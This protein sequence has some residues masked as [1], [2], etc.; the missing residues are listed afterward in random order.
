MEKPKGT[1]WP[2]QHCSFFPSL[3]LMHWTETMEVLNRNGW[4]GN[5]YLVSAHMGKVVG[6]SLLDILLAVNI[7][8]DA[9]YWIDKIIFYF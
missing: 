6:L 8:T 7:F 9:L 3:I 4:S 1:F 5:P 2:T